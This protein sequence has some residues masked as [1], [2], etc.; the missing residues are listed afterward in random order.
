MIRMLFTCLACLFYLL[1][2]SMS[3]YA[4][5]AKNKLYY[6]T[7]QIFEGER[8]VGE[9][10]FLMESGST[11][12]V[13]RANEDGYSLRSQIDTSDLQKSGQVKLS[14]LLYLAKS[15]GWVKVAQPNVTMKLN[16]KSSIS[17]PGVG[18]GA[19]RIEVSVS[20]DF[21]G[22]FAS[23]QKFG[24]NKCTAKKLARWAELTAMPVKASIALIQSE[25]V[26]GAGCC[27]PCSGM[28]R[29]SSGPICCSDSYV[30]PGGSCCN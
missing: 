28:T 23:T 20:D 21:S 5:P 3:G 29:C 10:K 14:S 24:Q 12:T 19:V 4:A 16:S 18:S 6:V 22:K 15:D 13:I 2:P 27:S 1:L 26:G 7:M 25:T 30:C 17:V 11:A 8:I 9:P